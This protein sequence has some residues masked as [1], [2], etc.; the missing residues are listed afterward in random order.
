MWSMKR[1]A[2]ADSEGVLALLW[3]NLS[4]GTRVKYKKSGNSRLGGEM[5][6]VCLYFSYTF[7][8]LTTKS[9][10]PSSSS[11][12]SIVCNQAMGHNFLATCRTLMIKLFEIRNKLE[13]NENYFTFLLRCSFC[14]VWILRALPHRR[15]SS[16]AVNV[17][18]MPWTLKSAWEN[19]ETRKKRKLRSS[20]L[21]RLS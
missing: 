18:R 21:F 3:V 20:E 9:T 4:N 12:R 17:L 5:E 6:W 8:V 19:R 7:L 2:L 13:E 1:I 11:S 16:L 10:A 14:S 15:F